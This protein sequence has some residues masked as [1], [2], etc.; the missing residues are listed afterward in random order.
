M[1]CRLGPARS[2]NRYFVEWRDQDVSHEQ[3]RI[4]LENEIEIEP[5]DHTARL[6]QI[7]TVSGYTCPGCGGPLWRLGNGVLDRYRR[8]VGHA[9]SGNSLFQACWEASEQNLYSALQLLEENARVGN[10]LIRKNDKNNKLASSELVDQVRR[11][12]KEADIL[13]NL[14]YERTLGRT[15]LA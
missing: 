14:L 2:S 10:Q 13:R 7:G 5:D 9:Y 12:E 6:Q 15:E 8:R 3:D 1:V 4:K 11:L